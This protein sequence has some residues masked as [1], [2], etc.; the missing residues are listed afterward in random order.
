MDSPWV[1]LPSTAPFVLAEDRLSVDTFNKLNR[2][3]PSWRIRTELMAEPFVGRVDAPL[4]ILALNP[5]FSRR[6]AHAHAR[7][8]FRSAVRRCI[9]AEPAAYPFFH[10]D[11][12]LRGPGADWWNL[13]LKELLDREYD[14]AVL[15]RS[16]LCLE[17]FPYHSISFAHGHLRLPSQEYTFSLLRAAIARNAPIIV[18]RGFSHWTGAVPELAAYTRLFRTR[19]HRVARISKRNCPLGFASACQVIEDA[20]V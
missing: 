20:L 19:T 13:A 3:R 1:H 14:R 16:I 11:P 7:P 17:F 6:D 4:V 2:K 5:G 9:S 10:L 18:T 12:A 15:A 8:E